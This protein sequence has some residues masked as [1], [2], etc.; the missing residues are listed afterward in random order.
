MPFQ[1]F[2]IVYLNRDGS[3]GTTVGTNP[4]LIFPR[5]LRTLSNGAPIT[6]RDFSTRSPG[7][8]PTTG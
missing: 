2:D 4:D 5:N 7:V 1:S 6:I 8:D 3:V